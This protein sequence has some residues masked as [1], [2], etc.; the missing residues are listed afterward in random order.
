LFVGLVVVVAV[1]IFAVLYYVTGGFTTHRLARFVPAVLALVTS[2]ALALKGNYFSAGFSGI[3]YIIFAIALFWAG[4][5]LL[6][7][8]FVMGRVRPQG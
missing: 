8:G 2:G 7:V 5:I 3:G 1:F 6:V 4:V